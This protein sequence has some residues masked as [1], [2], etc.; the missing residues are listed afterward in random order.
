MISRYDLVLT[1]K[2]KNSTIGLRKVISD[3]SEVEDIEGAVLVEGRD[4]IIAGNF[5]DTTDY[6]KEISEILQMLEDTTDSE[7][8]ENQN[9]IFEHSILDYNGLKILAKKL[10]ERLT[11]LV[12]IHNRGY[13]SLAMLDIENSIRKINEI[14]QGHSTYGAFTFQDNISV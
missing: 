12:V 6:K 14:L 2:T 10:K 1:G 7:K 11:L 5:P 3:L 4:E 9:H 8:I 13:I